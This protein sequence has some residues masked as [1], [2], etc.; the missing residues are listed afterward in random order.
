ME[1]LAV[2]ADIALSQKKVIHD[3]E[4]A[5][6]GDEAFDNEYYALSAQVVRVVVVVVVV[7]VVQTWSCAPASP[8]SGPP[9]IA[10]SFYY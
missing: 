8:F 2:R 6:A 9:T 7:V 5:G 10:F 4:V 3:I 1:E